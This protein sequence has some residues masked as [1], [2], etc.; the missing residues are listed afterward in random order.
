M[1]IT[2]HNYLTYMCVTHIFF[3]HFSFKVNLYLQLCLLVGLHGAKEYYIS[4]TYFEEQLR[5]F[6][7]PRF[8]LKTKQSKQKEKKTNVT[9]SSSKPHTP[10]AL[11]LEKGDLV[12]HWS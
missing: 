4:N 12:G 2:T 10:R 7:F 1:R 5:F 9:N 11:T 3:V 6:F 8:F